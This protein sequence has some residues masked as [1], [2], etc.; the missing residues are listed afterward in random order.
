MYTYNARSSSKEALRSPTKLQL[1]P[2]EDW[3]DPI[4]I[5]ALDPTLALGHLLFVIGQD[6]V[7]EDEVVLALELLEHIERRAGME[8]IGVND[9]SLG[10]D[11]IDARLFAIALVEQIAYNRLCPIR[12]IAQETKIG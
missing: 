2:G 6:E 1:S 7:I 10:S 11:F 3:R 12:S 9:A 4:E 5:L 8:D